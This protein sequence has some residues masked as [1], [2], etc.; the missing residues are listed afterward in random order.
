MKIIAGIYTLDEGEILFDGKP[1][2]ARKPVEALEKG[3]AMVHQELDLIPEMTVEENVFAGRER[4]KGPVVDKKWMLNRTKEL[5]KSLGI[6]IDPR[7]PVKY[8]STAQQQMVAIIRAIAFDAEVIIM[9]EPTSAIT[10]REVEKLFEIIRALKAQEKQSSI[11][12][13]KW[14]RS[15]S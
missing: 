11:F 4:S 8:L 7:M 3:I 10:D 6:S 2:V 15:T 14:M 13:I 9:D 12:P 5:M 1:F